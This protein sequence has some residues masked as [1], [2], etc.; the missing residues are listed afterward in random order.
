M[1]K[2]LI[3]SSIVC[4]LIPH[5]LVAE[6]VD[7]QIIQKTAT[8]N[9]ETLWG[10]V[11]SDA[12]IV[13]YDLHDDICAYMYNF[14]KNGQFPTSDLN[15][16][17]Y[18]PNDFGYILVNAKTHMDPVEAY[19]NGISD[20]RLWRAEIQ[21]MAE[22][23]LHTKDVM[24]DRAYL[25][26]PASKWYRYI[27][28]NDTVY[29]KKIP[30]P[31]IYNPDE[32]RKFVVIPWKKQMSEPLNKKVQTQERDKLWNEYAS[33]NGINSAE[34]YYNYIP[35]YEEVPYYA[36]HY[37][38]SPTSAAMCLG[39]YDKMSMKAGFDK[40][41][42]F[43]SHYFT[44]KD[45]V[46]GGVDFQIPDIQK[47]LADKM[48]TN[49]EG[50]TYIGNIPEGIEK[51]CSQKGHG[52]NADGDGNGYDLNYG[53]TSI[54]NQIKKGRPCLMNTYD[55]T[56]AVVGYKRRETDWGT[57]KYKFF[58][59]DTWDNQLHTWNFKDLY[60][61]V[62]IDVKNPLTGDIEIISPYSDPRYND[63]GFG[64]VFRTNIGNIIEW[65][66]T[67]PDYGQVDI[68]YRSPS[69]TI[70]IAEHTENDGSY[71]WHT[72]ELTQTNGARIDLIWYDL[73]DNVIAEDGTQS[74]ISLIHYDLPAIFDGRNAFSK[75]FPAQYK[76][77][78][79]ET[80][81]WAVLG[82]G[83]GPANGDNSLE[84][85]S[86]TSFEHL[87]IK[88]QMPSTPE[89][90]YKN[91]VIVFHPR[92]IGFPT[93]QWLGIE[94]WF[95]TVDQPEDHMLELRY[96]DQSCGLG[97]NDISWEPNQIVDVYNLV[98]NLPDFS[99][100]DTLQFTLTP[101][102]YN[103]LDIGFALFTGLTT[104][105]YDTLGTAKVL[106]YYVD[107]NGS[108]LG[109]TLT[110]DPEN[111][112]ALFTKLS[113]D[114]CALV[115]FADKPVYG[116]VDFNLNISSKEFVSHYTDISCD[117]SVLVAKNP[118]QISFDSTFI[119]QKEASLGA[120][121]VRGNNNSHW[122]LHAINMYTNFINNRF[123]IVYD[124]VATSEY[125]SP[126]TNFCVFDF[127][128]LEKL[129]YCITSRSKGGG[130]ADARFEVCEA[131]FEKGNLLTGDWSQKDLVKVW[132]LNTERELNSK[133]TYS[134][135]ITLDERGAP[136]VSN[137]SMTVVPLASTADTS[138]T[139]ISVFSRRDM[140][141]YSPVSDRLTGKQSIEFEDTPG[142]YAIV[143]WTDQP[144]ATSY[145]LNLNIEETTG[146]YE[147][148]LPLNFSLAQNYP[149]P[150]NDAT[151]L[152]YDLAETG[153]VQLV[154]YNLQGEIIKTVVHSSQAP[155]S[156]QLRWNG[157]DQA[158]KQVSTG[159]YFYKLVAGEKV[160]TRKMVLMR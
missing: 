37:G 12:P 114:T 1:L 106:N 32:F 58:V 108:G 144:V 44:E 137:L 104:Y 155:G 138:D 93:E 73:M 125:P 8:E 105:K 42:L 91:N 113:Q 140:N 34:W 60:S 6:Q 112:S 16:E 53:R 70:L 149:N 4:T 96:S 142:R 69:D 118:T 15:N 75:T 156:Y 150:F 99:Y 116:S 14:S 64:Q 23:A 74:D 109:E 94:T 13:Y 134:Y 55:H 130:Y 107:E 36:W 133:G 67:N 39:Y 45:K 139:T 27:S 146:V 123:F 95:P 38:C 46:E 5:S 68:I 120:F 22:R 100:E 124:T 151:T 110:L 128:T 119:T 3:I 102:E 33:G 158:G 87:Q 101:S 2:K 7:Y 115:L 136:S 126:E 81:P 143:L 50:E 25:I 51:A 29:I 41:G 71:I 84:L 65:E 129:P 98:I 24:L 89:P 76:V 127:S 141:G 52:S 61:M 59:H 148:N 40:Y 48:N 160:E 135:N 17:N 97:D 26:D 43:V 30:P 103:N 62:K 85:Y 28:A 10:N 152:N 145:E 11:Y 72:P 117:T 154:I 21:T 79:P 90:E 92:S 88:H 78:I 19:G 9:A 111:Y 31:K 121:A 82:F 35:H 83:I 122:G 47:V 77:K 18:R 57:A 54:V 159:V 49:S 131:S 86:S 153:P 56:V 80:Y 157:T 147:R 132:E 66:T 63:R 20:G